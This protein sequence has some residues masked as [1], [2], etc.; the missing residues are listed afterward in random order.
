[1]KSSS[2]DAQHSPPHSGAP[3]QH[4]GD[5]DAEYLGGLQV[6]GRSDAIRL[7]V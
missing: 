2:S 6:D 3:E 1:M 7:D 4:R 5:I